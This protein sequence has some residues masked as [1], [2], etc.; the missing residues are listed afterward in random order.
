M[1]E[2]TA[3]TK[4]CP[5]CGCAVHDSSG[6]TE[7]LLDERNNWRLGCIFF[8]VLLILRTLPDWF[9]VFS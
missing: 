1:S 7:R 4:F 3:D 8:A 5:R 2:Q 6:K 9:R